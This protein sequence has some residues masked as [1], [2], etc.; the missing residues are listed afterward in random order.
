M[1]NW[2]RFVWWFV[3]ELRSSPLAYGPRHSG[4]RHCALLSPTQANLEISNETILP[5]EVEKLVAEIGTEVGI[6]PDWFNFEAGPLIEF[7]FPDGMITRL[8]KKAY[9]VCLTVYFISRFDQVHFKMLA[10]MSPEDGTRHLGDLLDLSPRENEVEAAVAWL[11]RRKT[12]PEF[13][14][15]LRGLLDRIGYERI[16]EQI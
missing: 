3:V 8:V 9:G 12:S 6:R 10:A 2:N 14:A 1:R 13:K 7:G 11:L 5:P 4:R 16:A 15:A